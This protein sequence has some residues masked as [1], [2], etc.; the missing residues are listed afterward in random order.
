[1][2]TLVVQA[3][4]VDGILAW[5][6]IQFASPNRAHIPICSPHAATVREICPTV[7]AALQ[8][9]DVYGPCVPWHGVTG[10]RLLYCTRHAAAEL[11]PPRWIGE[12]VN[13]K[14]IS[15]KH[16]SANLAVSLG[17]QWLHIYVCT[18]RVFPQGKKTE[19]QQH[20]N[21]VWHPY[22]SQSKYNSRPQAG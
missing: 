9:R 17:W 11:N 14:P 15:P 3:L 13:C 1:M 18:T 20:C 8:N 2:K 6:A 5:S 19:K 12:P 10:S 16:P 22:M 21:M 4:S 7:E